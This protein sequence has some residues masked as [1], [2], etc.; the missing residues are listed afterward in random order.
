MAPVREKQ[1]SNQAQ[2]SN[3]DTDSRAGGA[4]VAAV[5]Q[6]RD[7]YFILMRPRNLFTARAGTAPEFRMG[8]EGLVYNARIMASGKI[9]A[10][11]Q[12]S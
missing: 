9:P 12:H 6:T 11:R 1:Q 4:G 3:D 5:I 10:R 8:G 2:R 7:E